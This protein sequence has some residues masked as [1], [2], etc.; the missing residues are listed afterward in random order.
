VGVRPNGGYYDIDLEGIVNAFEH[1]LVFTQEDIHHLI[2]TDRDFMWNK[3]IQEAKFRRIDGGPPD[4]RWKNSPGVLWTALVPYDETLCKV[5][6]ANHNQVI[7]AH[8]VRHPDTSRCEPLL[9][10]AD[11]RTP[12]LYSINS[13]PLECL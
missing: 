5:F 9:A 3:K 10:S 6:V 1:G 11:P 12:G 13:S 7:G 2:A 8:W 4:S